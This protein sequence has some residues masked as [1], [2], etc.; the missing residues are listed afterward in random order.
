MK[1]SDLAARLDNL[2]PVWALCRD[3]DIASNAATEDTVQRHVTY[4]GEPAQVIRMDRGRALVM[5]D[6]EPESTFAWC[7]PSE[8]GGA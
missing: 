3:L 1:S 6:G 2:G 8:L 4:R 5:V 7:Y